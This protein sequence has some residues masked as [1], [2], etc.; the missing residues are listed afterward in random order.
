MV[1]E[2]PADPKDA[3]LGRVAESERFGTKNRVRVKLDEKTG[4]PVGDDSDDKNVET[5]LGYKDF[6]PLRMNPGDYIAVVVDMDDGVLAKESFS[7]VPDWDQDNKS[8]Q[9]YGVRA[10]K[11]STTEPKAEKTPASEALAKAVK[12][13]ED[14]AVS[15]S[16]EAER[17]AMQE[18]QVAREAAKSAGHDVPPAPAS[19]AKP[20]ET[21][22]EKA[23]KKDTPEARAQKG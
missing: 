7:I 4:M 19:D 11:H 12:R 5:H 20:V 1:F 21:K 3:K 14:P 22:E 13:G 2:D 16:N 15:A 8:D 10:P 9:V 18:T 23:A 17:A 6:G